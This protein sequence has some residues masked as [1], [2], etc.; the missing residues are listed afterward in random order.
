MSGSSGKGQNLYVEHYEK[1]G[2]KKVTDGSLKPND[3]ILMALNNNKPRER[4]YGQL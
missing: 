1:E 3:V 2:F 4:L